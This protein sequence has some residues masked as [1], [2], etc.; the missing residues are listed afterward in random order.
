MNLWAVLIGIAV[1]GVV[2]G[3]KAAI[4]V[5]KAKNSK[6][7]TPEEIAKELKALDEN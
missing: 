6:S 4:D 7:K 2:L 5:I 3:I 1:T